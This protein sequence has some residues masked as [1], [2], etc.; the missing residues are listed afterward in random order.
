MTSYN[1]W[2]NRVMKGGPYDFTDLYVMLAK[3]K[4]NTKEIKKYLALKTA[5]EIRLNNLTEA[6]KSLI[7]FKHFAGSICLGQPFESNN[8]I[9]GDAQKSE[10][11]C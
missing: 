1:L 9:Q 5:L 4:P 10:T 2:L 3:I 6:Q 8:F 7:S 11:L